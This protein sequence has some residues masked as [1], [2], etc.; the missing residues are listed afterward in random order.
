MSINY[1]FTRLLSR[2]SHV[3][4]LKTSVTLILLIPLVDFFLISLVL[5]TIVSFLFFEWR[6]SIH[7][8]S[9]LRNP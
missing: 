3:S 6:V 4:P 5:F 2:S 9:F 1:Y 7:S 8:E